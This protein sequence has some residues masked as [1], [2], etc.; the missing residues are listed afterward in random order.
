MNPYP[1]QPAG[2]PPSSVEYGGVTAPAP[3]GG[4]KSK[5]GK[6]SKKNKAAANAGNPDD[7]N[8]VSLTPAAEAY[9]A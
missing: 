7:A 8:A 6:R 4:R 3:G 9:S 1:G 5:K 2:M